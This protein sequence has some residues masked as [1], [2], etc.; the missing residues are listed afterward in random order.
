MRGMILDLDDTLY[1]RADFVRS[2]F[3]AIAQY[4]SH[5]WRLEPEAVSATLLSAHAD[6]RQG[7]EFQAV[8]EEH[9][10]PLSVVPALV[11]VFRKHMPRLVLPADT[12]RGL[13]ELRRHGWRLVVLTN[14]NPSV[15]RRKVAALRLEPLVD[16]VIYAEE[17]VDGGKP[18]P[19][20]FNRALER[21]RLTPSE[22]ICVGDD[23]ICDIDGA[24]RLGLRTIRV[25]TRARSRRLLN[26][27]DAVVAS[28][29]EVPAYARLLLAETSDAA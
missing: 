1:N 25:I 22:C 19:A 28:I 27:A 13:S 21:L 15:Q 6:G 18:H 23:P 7:R 4:V 26:E 20:T 5:S 11:S 3:D 9:R 24:R 16:D 14:G 12:R 8:C 17:I 2:G 10:L 29:V